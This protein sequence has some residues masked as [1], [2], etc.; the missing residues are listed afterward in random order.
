MGEEFEERIQ[1]LKNELKEL[2]DSVSTEEVIAGMLK[3]AI[4]KKEEE[5]KGRLDR[6]KDEKLKESDGQLQEKK[7]TFNKDLGTRKG[8]LIEE[9]DKQ[10]GEKKKGFV[11]DLNKEG[12]TVT[13]SIETAK[14]EAKQ[15]INKEL[16]TKIKG[17]VKVWFEEWIKNY[18]V[19]NMLDAEK[20]RL[21][22]ERS[23]SRHQMVSRIVIGAALTA[24]AVAVFIMIYKG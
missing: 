6:K 17:T 16:E 3:L 24:L 1:Q 9:I 15:Y 8:E 12:N 11:D 21:N 7:N 23:K 10:L 22:M 19:A 13:K 2:K 5:F 4:E 20:E 14:M 18:L